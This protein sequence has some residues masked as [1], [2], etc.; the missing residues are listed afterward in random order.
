MLAL[1]LGEKIRAAR[2]TRNLT[3]EELAEQL[4]VTRAAVSKWENAESYPDITIL[5]QIAQLFHMTIDE[6]FGYVLE[7]KPLKIINQYHFGFSLDDVDKRILNYGTVKECG[8][9]P[10]ERPVEENAEK[11]W[12]VRIHFISEEEH[13]PYI[14]QK[15]IKPGILIDGYSVRE[16]DGKVM[17]DVLPNKHYVCSKKVWEYKTADHEYL[18]QM[19]REQIEMGLI[20]DKDALL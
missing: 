16:V 7:P 5:P 20:D 17:D 3:Q 10:C 18:M 14:L 13:F 1:K 9:Y 2:K 11:T 12:E 19:L 15:Y 8:I 4:G 6:L